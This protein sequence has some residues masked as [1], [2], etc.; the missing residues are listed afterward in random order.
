[1]RQ[2]AQRTKKTSERHSTLVGWRF[3]CKKVRNIISKHS[4][5]QFYQAGSKK[6]EES[7]FDM[8]PLP[9]IAVPWKY[10]FENYVYKPKKIR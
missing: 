6:M 3:F 4:V 5:R 8:I 7:M 2:Y 9:I 10:V 1:V